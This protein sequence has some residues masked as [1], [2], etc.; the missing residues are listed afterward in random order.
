MALLPTKRKAAVEVDT[1]R[2][3]KAERSIVFGTDDVAAWKQIPSAEQNR[4]N[5]EVLAK[6]SMT[7]DELVS[8]HTIA[9]QEQR[10]NAHASSDQGLSASAA[11]AAAAP[12]ARDMPLLFLHAP[13]TGGTTFETIVPKNYSINDT[14]QLNGPRASKKP[15]LLFKWDKLPHALMGHFELNHRLYQSIERRFVHMTILREPIRRVVSLYNWM[16]SPGHPRREQVGQMT[17]AEFAAEKSIVEAHNGQTLRFAGSLFPRYA[18]KPELAR[19]AFEVAR[20]VLRK[21]IT[22]FGILES[23]D[24]MLV[25]CERLLGWNDPYYRRRNVSTGGVRFGDL[26]EA[27]VAIIRENNS[28]DIQLYDEA[29]AL[30]DQRLTSLGVTDAMVAD[31]RERNERWAELTAGVAGRAT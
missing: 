5:L 16:H 26:D 7:W 6:Y 29:C 4:L 15:E 11:G 24:T 14:L 3:I 10:G 1:A 2:L 27:T 9:S 17:L 25:L 23:F 20:E 22:L 12:N 30:Q 21:R 28:F 19:E 31:F 13:K 18:R 8:G